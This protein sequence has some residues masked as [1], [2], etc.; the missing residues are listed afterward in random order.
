MF[1]FFS[2]ALAFLFF[3][4]SLLSDSFEFAPHIAVDGTDFSSFLH[5]LDGSSAWFSSK[6]IT[7]SHIVWHFTIDQS[8]LLFINFMIFIFFLLSLEHFLLAAFFC[9]ADIIAHCAL[10]LKYRRRKKID[11]EAQMRPHDSLHNKIANKMRIEHK[12]ANWKRTKNTTVDCS[13]IIVF[14]IFL[15]FNAA[16]CLVLFKQMKIDE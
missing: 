8:I 3:S 13:N 7:Y 12:K 5:T 9:T 10:C 11:C 4:I 14:S 15:W 6:I 2:L 1:S 16:R